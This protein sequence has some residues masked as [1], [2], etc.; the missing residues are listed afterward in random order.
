MASSI[1][2]FTLIARDLLFGNPE[3]VQAR[4]SP[5]GTKLS[6]LAPHGGVMNI[7]VGPVSDPGAAK[8]VTADTGRGIRHYEWAY[9]GSALLYPQDKNG[10]ENW[11]LYRT[12]LASGQTTNL[13][14]LDEV[15]A[16]IEALSPSVPEEVL[17]GLNDR[18]P[19]AHDLYRLN[20]TTGERSFVLENEEGFLSFI[21]D[22]QLR[23]RFGVRM[24]PDGGADI[25]RRTATGSWASF[26]SV[27]VEDQMMTGPLGLDASGKLLYM[28]DSRN[29]DTA[30]LVALD[31][32]TGDETVLAEDARAD[33]G[34]TLL[35]PTLKTVQAVSVEYERSSWTVLDE[36]LSE[37]F[38]YLNTVMSGDLRIVDR[39]L[40][41]DKWMVVYL[42]DNGPQS[43]YLY[44]RTRQQA[45]RLFVSQPELE[46]APLVNM[47]PQILDSRDGYKLVSYLSLP[48][49]VS[50]V[51]PDTPLPMVLLVHGGPWGRDSW[52]FDS[53]HQWLANR[54]YAV[55][56]VNFRGSTGFGKDFLNAGNRA[57]GAEMH[58]DLLDAV[59]W[60]TREG[61]AQADKVAIMGGSY[62][63]YATLAGLAFTPKVFAA[64]V[65]IVGPSNLI[66]LIESIP[67]YWKPML[68]MLTSRVGDPSTEQGEALLKA[69]SPLSKADAISKPLLIGQGANDPRVKQAESDQIVAAMQEKG[70]PVT[71]ALYPD[72][73][74]GF[75]RPANRLSF[76]ALTEAFLAA[77]LDGRFEPIGDALQDSSL[78]VVTGAE[79]IPGLAEAVRE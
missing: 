47:H 41:D 60:A 14:P 9:S 28:T 33:V 38:A 49:F 30:A 11:H 46:D 52:S 48:P 43:Y 3:K 7:W 16:H 35:H 73:G 53:E 22:A 40:A 68:S 54:G 5:D 55:L 63:G 34:D 56:S 29:R 61:I 67:P 71:Y 77:H 44:D 24:T 13:T 72:E 64:G 79:Q 6:Y 31:L 18:D 15:Q 25:F 66:T 57:W 78:Q 37:D 42:Q 10:D 50:G 20:L 69:R 70:I 62:G 74:H 65:D 1:N 12:N 45:H 26:A 17:I 32:H 27:G 36:T 51:R 19:A 75:A 8:P 2:A 58:H 76:Y 23:V 4:L 39:T 21:A 59:E